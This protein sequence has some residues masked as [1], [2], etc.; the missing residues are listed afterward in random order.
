MVVTT[1]PRTASVV[2]LTLD[3]NPKYLDNSSWLVSILLERSDDG[4]LFTPLA[5]CGPGNNST[6]RDLGKLE[7]SLDLVNTFHVNSNKTPIG[8]ESKFIRA[9]YETIKGFLEASIFITF[10]HLDESVIAEARRTKAK[11]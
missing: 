5:R 10:D 3:I 4:K 1:I 9:S 8:L 7:M 6:L 11:L 2:Y